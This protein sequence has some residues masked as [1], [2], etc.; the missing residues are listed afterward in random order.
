MRE[1]DRKRHR[2]RKRLGMNGEIESGRE[3][4]KR[5]KKELE[6]VGGRGDEK[7]DRKCMRE[8]VRGEKERETDREI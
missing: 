6:R 5:G 2:G 4:G 7:R 8:R 1:R 3:R